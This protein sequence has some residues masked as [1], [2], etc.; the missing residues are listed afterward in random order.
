LRRF[1]I[2][3]NKFVRE[4]M[5]RIILFVVVSVFIIGILLMFS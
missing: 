1:S 4:L 5:E 3:L 2:R